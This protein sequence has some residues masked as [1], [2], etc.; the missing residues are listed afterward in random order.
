M[1]PLLVPILWLGWFCM[2]LRIA[3]EP[4]RQRLPEAQSGRLLAQVQ[5]STQAKG[6]WFCC[7]EASKFRNQEKEVLAKGVSAESSVTPKE[8]K[9]IQG[10][11][12]QLYL[13]HSEHHSQERR[14]L[15]KNPFLKPPFSWLLRSGQ[16]VMSSLENGQPP[17]PLVKQD[18][19]TNR[20]YP[21]FVQSRSSFNIGVQIP[22]LGEKFLIATCPNEKFKNMFET[23]V[24]VQF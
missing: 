24:G 15:C 10:Y 17:P 11:W 21:G 6:G 8:P 23:V 3:L 14:T 18:H 2:T 4:Q 22:K 12:A 13:W 16:L 7:F 5:T 9:N 1:L 19:L 20:S